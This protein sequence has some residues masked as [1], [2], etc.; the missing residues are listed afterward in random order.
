MTPPPPLRPHPSRHSRGSA[1]PPPSKQHHHR[2]HHVPATTPRGCVWQPPHHKGA[3]GL[4][5]P[6]EGV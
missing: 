5:Q 6:E 4:A 3:F 2:H 1:T